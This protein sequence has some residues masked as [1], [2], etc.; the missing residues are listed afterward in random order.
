MLEGW[1]VPSPWRQI[2]SLRRTKVSRRSMRMDFW[3]LIFGWIGSPFLRHLLW[4]WDTVG[5]GWHFHQFLILECQTSWP[6]KMNKDD[7]TI[8]QW[9]VDV[10]VVFVL[11]FTAHGRHLSRH[12]VRARARGVDADETKSEAANAIQSIPAYVEV[13]SAFVALV[14]SLKEAGSRHGHD[15]TSW[16]ARGHKRQTFW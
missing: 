6:N 11:F 15:Y 5:G 14:P 13:S 16:L 2:L 8:C 7:C 4:R 1:R 10:W 12:E 3:M 9:F